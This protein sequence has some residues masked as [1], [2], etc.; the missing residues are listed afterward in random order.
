MWRKYCFKL[1]VFSMYKVFIWVLMDLIWNLWAWSGSRYSAKSD[2]YPGSGPWRTRSFASC[3]NIISWIVCSLILV[4]NCF[5]LSLF[6]SNAC[7]TVALLHAVINNKEK[8]GL[9][10]GALMVR[11]YLNTFCIMSRVEGSQYHNSFMKDCF[12]WRYLC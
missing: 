2:P 1:A 10:E 6:Y 4:S 9:K 12:I 8:I 3:R 5:N 7:G 11:K